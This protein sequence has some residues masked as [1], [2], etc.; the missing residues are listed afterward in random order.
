MRFI[1]TNPPWFSSKN[2]VQI[3]IWNTKMVLNFTIFTYQPLWFPTKMMSK[4]CLEYQNW[5]ELCEFYISTPL[6]FDLNDVQ[7]PFG[8]P[9]LTWTMRF[10]H[11]NPLWFPNKKCHF[12]C[13]ECQNGVAFYK[14]YTPTPLFSNKK[15][16]FMV[17]GVLKWTKQF[18]VFSI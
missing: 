17:L 7:T 4:W 15:M 8:V 3:G 5:L 11:T 12:W 1:H 14:F 16:Y 13:W 18:L 9:K 6:V 10:L 2:K